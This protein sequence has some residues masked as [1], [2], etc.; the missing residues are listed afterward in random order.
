[1][2]LC[3]GEPPVRFL[4]CWLLLLFFISLLLMW[5]WSS[6]CFSISSLTL[7]WTIA[8]FLH[9]FYTFS[10]AHRRVIRDTFISNL[11]E[12]FF[13]QF[14]RERYSFELA[15][16]T[17]RRFLPYA[18]W[19]RI[20]CV[21][22]GLPGSWQFFLEVFRASYWFSKH[23]PCPSVCLIHSNAQSS[24]S[25]WFIFK[26]YQTPSWITCGKKFSLYAS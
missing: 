16:F 2:F 9:P 20:I 1:M 12:I 22:Q 17:H 3:L 15:F 21:Y 5:C 10:P 19:L 8:E 18:P 11:S 13:S 24:Y 6:H 4:W 23:K 25:E 7:P 26:F 14:Y